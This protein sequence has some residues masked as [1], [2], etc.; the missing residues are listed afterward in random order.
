MAGA[1]LK[2]V[3]SVAKITLDSVDDFGSGLHSDHS[4]PYFYEAAYMHNVDRPHTL[5]VDECSRVRPEGCKDVDV[6]SWGCSDKCKPLSESEV[7]SILELR[8]SFDR[9]MYD[10]RKALDRCDECANT[11]Y[12]KVLLAGGSA[13]SVMRVGHPLICFLGGGDCRS[14]VRIL[15]AASVHFPVLRSFLRCVYLALGSHRCVA[16]PDVALSEGDFAGVARACGMSAYDSLFSKQEEAVVDLSDADFARLPLRKREIK[17]DLLT[18]HLKLIAEYEKAIEDYLQH[19]CCS[20]NMLFY[21]KGGSAVHFRDKLGPVWTSLKKFIAAREPG[22]AKEFF[23]CTYCKGHMR[24]G[25]MPPRCMLNSLSTVPMPEELSRLDCLSRQFVQ[26]AKAF[27]SVVRLGTYTHK[28]PI[29]NFLKACKGTMFFL[30][31][32]LN[33]TLATLDEAGMPDSDSIAD[34]EVY[35]IVNGKPTKSKVVWRSLVNVDHIREAVAKLHEI[36]PLY[37]GIDDDSVDS[38]TRK[39]IE[40]I[41]KTSSTMLEKASKADIAGLQCYTIKNTDQALL[42]TSDIDQ[43]KLMSVEEDPLDNR[44]R[45]LDVM[46]FPVLFPDGNFGKYHPR[47]VKLSHSEY[48]KSRLWNRDSWFRKDLQY[49][50]SYSGRRR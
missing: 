24:S 5:C 33:R 16:N 14:K 26:R 36:N 13:C 32:P 23:M 38:A 39:V 10:L 42:A 40:V 48:I 44:Q 41:S 29:Y 35:I 37:K 25:S 43:Y 34:P 8:R 4:E 46:C 20:C 18:K 9:F 50:S 22:A 19:P 28:V 17:L 30:P 15:R 1:L 47:E 2:S 11:H 3:R 45:H 21:R 12:S 49:I 27:Q 6:R 7:S 31:L